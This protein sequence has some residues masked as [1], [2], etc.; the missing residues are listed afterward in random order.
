MGNVENCESYINIP[1]SHTYSSYFKFVYLK[2]NWE[3][4]RM[5]MNGYGFRCMCPWRFLLNLGGALSSEIVDAHEHSCLHINLL[6]PWRMASSGMF[7]S[8][9]VV[10]TDVSE[11]LRV[12]FIR[13][14]RIG[15]LGT[16]LVVTTNQRKLRRN[17]TTWYFL[18]ACVGC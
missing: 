2:V 16:T 15:E 12:S 6:S 1:S 3:W 9:A 4:S 14:T 18:A 7:R 5:L 11:E 8:V 17:T 10:R 13:V